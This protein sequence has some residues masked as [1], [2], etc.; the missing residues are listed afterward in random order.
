MVSHPSLSSWVWGTFLYST[1]GEMT[2]SGSPH[3]LQHAAKLC[4]WVRVGADLPNQLK[5]H[6]HILA[7]LKSTFGRSLVVKRKVLSSSAASDALIHYPFPQFCSSSWRHNS[8]SSSFKVYNS[9]A[10]ARKRL[11]SEE[12]SISFI[13]EDLLNSSQNFEGIPQWWSSIGD[14]HPGH[15]TTLQSALGVWSSCHDQKII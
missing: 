8:F 10:K 12:S 6:H 11:H 4:L 9:V 13:G 1:A 2:A 3:M 15:F 7:S 5:I 14:L